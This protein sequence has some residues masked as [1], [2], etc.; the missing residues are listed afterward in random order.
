MKKIFSSIL[1]LSCFLVSVLFFTG[2]VSKNQTPT[3]LPPSEKPQTQTPEQE[4]KFVALGDSMTKA[5]NLSS[6]LQGDHEE[7]SFSTGAQINSAYQYLKEKGENLT[8]VNLASSGATSKDILAK[9]VPNASSYH[10]RYITLLTGGPDLGSNVSLAVFKNNLRQIVSQLKKE[11][12]MILLATIPNINQ[13][14]KGGGPACQTNKIGLRLENFTPQNLEAWNQTIKDVAEEYNCTLIDLYPILNQNDVSD[15][16]CLHPN[17]Q[18]QEKIAK[19]FIK[20]LQ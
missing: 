17:L 18:G 11:D 15:Y 4:R 9:Q 19:E 1:L 13:M 12:I 10:P 6:A 7:Y 14:R 2:C 16:D 20:S 5:N 8:A 3:S